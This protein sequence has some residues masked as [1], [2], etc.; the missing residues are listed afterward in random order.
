ME[1]FYTLLNIA[2]RKSLLDQQSSWSNG[3]KTYLNEIKKEINEVIEES[4]K[5]RDCYLE[6][7]LGDVL[8]DYLNALVAFEKEKGINPLSVLER[9]CRKY[10]ERVGGL[11]SGETW[12][13]VKKRQNHRLQV[14]HSASPSKATS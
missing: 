7:E 8:W 11:E 1:E 14:E 13:E 9:A 5:G 4:T 10:E 12:D 3:S 6:D 2:K